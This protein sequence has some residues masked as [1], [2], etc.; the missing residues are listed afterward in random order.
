MLAQWIEHQQ[1]CSFPLSTMITQAKVKGL[2]ENLNAVEP[3][4][5][6]QSFGA[7]AGC[8]NVLKGAMDS[9]TLS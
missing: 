9:T 5:K 2:F 3:D 4:M 1:Q 7:S 8:M 6:V